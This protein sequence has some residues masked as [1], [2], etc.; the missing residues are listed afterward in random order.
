[1]GF[2]ELGYVSISEIEEA[3]QV[4]HYLERDTSFTGKYPLSVYARAA[5]NARH[6]VTDD[7]SLARAA[8]KL[9]P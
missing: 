6:I 2:P 7:E 8:P 4:F 1:M 9:R 3:Q 5:L